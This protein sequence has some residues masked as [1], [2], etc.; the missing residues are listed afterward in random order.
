[1]RTLARKCIE[2]VQ[3]SLLGDLLVRLLPV[4]TFALAMVPTETSHHGIR[5]I[6]AATVALIWMLVWAFGFFAIHAGPKGRL[7]LER[8][9]DAPPRA[10]GVWS[11]SPAGGFR[12]PRLTRAIV[13]ALGRPC[14]R[15]LSRLLR[16]RWFGRMVVAALLAPLFVLFISRNAP[17]LLG[18]AAPYFEQPG[19]GTGLVWVWLTETL[20]LT[21]RSWA[22]D[23]R[24]QLAHAPQSAL[25]LT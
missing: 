4:S 17:S 6:V 5:D 9:Q 23:F 3:N 11:Q 13:L 7:T 2:A 16:R 20:I 21:V 18:P 24:V 14:P 22:I 25:R 19:V 8:I 10:F 12:P 1:M 15:P